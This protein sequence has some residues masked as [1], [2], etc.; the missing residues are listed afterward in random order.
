MDAADEL[1][2][3]RRGLGR[4]ALELGVG[5]AGDEARDG[6]GQLDHLHQA[7]VGGEARNHEARLSS[8]CVADR[9]CSPRSGGGGARRRGARRRPSHARVP[10]THLAGVGAQA[11][12][13]ALV[14]HVL[15]LGHEVDDEG[16]APLG[17]NSAEV[18][19]AKPHTSRAN[20]QTAAC[21]PRQMPRIREHCCSRAW[22]AAAI[23]PS[24]ARAPKPPGTRMPSHAG[25]AP[26]RRSSSVSSSPSTKC[27]L[28]LAL[29][30]DSRHGARRL[31]DGEVGVGQA[32]RTCPPRQMS[33]TSSFLLAG[34]LGVE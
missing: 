11:H 30:S 24:M 34:V 22:R 31:V 7:L 15:L 8:S 32:A 28:H 21:R 19:P 29:R 9:R 13:A 16:A 20:S 2:E 27:T 6:P 17:S 18:A 33:M 5:L 25:R 1:A 3:E 23:L 10:G 4:A 26:R 14:F 12:G